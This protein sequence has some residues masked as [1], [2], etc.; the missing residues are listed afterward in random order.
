VFGLMGLGTHYCRGS[1]RAAWD[2]GM[3][4]VVEL[5]EWAEVLDRNPGN[6]QRFLDQDR[7]QFIATFE[8]WMAAYCPGGGELVP[9][10]SEEEAR[11]LDFPALVLR[12]GTTDLSHR[13]E[14]SE[15]VA[16]V[17]P[18]ARLVEPPWGDNEWNER[19]AAREGGQGEGLFAGWPQLAPLL[20]DWA[21]EILG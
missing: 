18:K 5:E 21:G 14:T 6:R 3:E 7:A 9:G 17:L 8:R 19:S 4:A 20:L 11:K 13:R 12:S 2:G 16:A 1:I 15:K 10:L